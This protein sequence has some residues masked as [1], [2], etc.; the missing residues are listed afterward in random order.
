MAKTP[1]N[2]QRKTREMI[3]EGYK[4]TVAYAAAHAMRRRGRLGP[5]GGYRRTH[6][7]KRGPVGRQRRLRS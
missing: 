6:T 7:T 1:K 3:A 2:V 4:P 5:Q